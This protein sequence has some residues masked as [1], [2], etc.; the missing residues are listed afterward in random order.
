MRDLYSAPSDM[1]HLLFFVWAVSFYKSQALPTI[2]V[3]QNKNCLQKYP[4]NYDGG[5]IQTIQDLIPFS[6]DDVDIQ[7]TG[8]QSQCS[9][10]PNIRIN[11]RVYNGV[12]NISTLGAILDVSLGI[13]TS[14]HI[15]AAIDGM[16]NACKSTY[17]AKRIEILTSVIQSLDVN[18]GEVND[19]LPSQC[20]CTTVMAHA[21]VLRADAY[22]ELV[23]RLDE[24]VD[25]ALNDAEK[26]TKS[27]VNRLNGR[28]WRVL[29]DAKEAKNDI[30]GAMQALKEW[31]KSSPKF[32]KKALAEL[33]RL[34]KLKN[35]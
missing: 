6:Y 31:S 3:C 28:S 2:Q 15:M 27:R 5:L 20:T 17:P 10:G 14:G 1:I 32:S 18:Q 30:A 12:D 24:N 26:A 25:S 16:A 11:D 34:A 22:L 19:S 23:P 4:R 8:C 21:L 29:A 33:D 9:L 35:T 7:G 13:D